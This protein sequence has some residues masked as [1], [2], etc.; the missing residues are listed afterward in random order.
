MCKRSIYE[1]RTQNKESKTPKVWPKKELWKHS[2]PISG[3]CPAF[4]AWQECWCWPLGAQAG[5]EDRSQDQWAAPVLCPSEVLE[6]KMKVPKLIVALWLMVAQARA[7]VRQFH[8]S[9]TLVSLIKSRERR[10]SRGEM[11]RV[12]C[13][14]LTRVTVGSKHVTNIQPNGA[15]A[16]WRVS[17][18]KATRSSRQ[19]NVGTT[20]PHE[21]ISLETNW[22][23]LCNRWLR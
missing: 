9:A 12:L 21:H 11:E 13:R 8:D 3:N 15:D 14:Y 20:F 2:L 17:A 1:P 6:K 10:A 18:Q 23:A 4:P 19:H 22:T 5:N 16:H 7:E